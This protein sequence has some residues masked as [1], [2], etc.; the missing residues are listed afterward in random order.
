M[1]P[2][3]LDD[4]ALD[5]V[6][7]VEERLESN[8]LAA[9][10]IA[11]HAPPESASHPEVQLARARALV[12][13]KG[14]AS[15]K[16]VLEALA[17]REPDFAEARHLYAQVLEELG[18]HPASVREML[19]VRRLDAA[20]DERDGFDL[21]AVEAPIVSTAE[22]VLGELPQRFKTLLAGVPVL[23]EDRP[24]EE[25]VRDGFDPRSL[26]LFSGPDQAERAGPGVAPAPTHIVLY[27]ANLAAFAD[28]N[29]PEELEHEVEITL[30][31]EI[32]HYFGLD[33]DGLEALGLG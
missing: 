25:L 27:A 21:A 1:T 31:H 15:A 11:E 30:L 28:P 18:E 20:S 4:R 26:G 6:L 5:V 33:E 24:S 17:H 9:L 12:A 14:A 29:D 8:P 7:E 22:K 16:P 19:V 32:G 13:A 2:D 10:D 3:E 23:V